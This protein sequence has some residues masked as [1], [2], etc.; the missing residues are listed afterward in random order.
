LWNT[1]QDKF[2]SGLVGALEPMGESL[3]VQLVP[4]AE[5]LGKLVG[6]L[7]PPLSRIGTALA[8]GLVALMPLLQ[9]V[10][11]GLAVGV[12]AIMGALGPAMPQLG[13]AFAE[14]GKALGEF[15]VALAPVA[16]DLVHLFASLVG[17]LPAFIRI[18]EAF[19]PL[20]DPMAKLLAIIV[21]FG[22]TQGILAGLLGVMLGYRALHG[23]A[24]GIHA[25]RL[26]LVA[27]RDAKGVSGVVQALATGGKPMAGMAGGVAGQAAGGAGAA[28]AGAM[29]S[30]FLPGAAVV[31]GSLTALSGIREKE[32]ASSAL[33]TIGGMGATGAGIGA[34]IGTPFFGVGA[35]PAAAIGGALGLGVGGAMAGVRALMGDS[36]DS[37]RGARHGAAGIAEGSTPGS[38]RV[39]SH[40]RTWGLASDSSGH[41][42]SRGNAVDVVGPFLASYRQAV[43]DAGGYAEFHGEGPSR[44]VHAVGDSPM[45][46][47]NATMAS[48]RGGGGAL[49][50][51]SMTVQTGPIS[52]EV[53]L[54]RAIAAGARRAVMELDRDE[55]ERG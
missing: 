28:G 43:R 53:D 31:G 51:L 52:A 7:A 19:L 18:L 27:L 6:A 40:V 39:T 29:A 38:R 5:N 8:V 14:L 9:P 54:E 3:K 2:Q 16:P 30:K 41:H 22:P 12:E 44:H 55:R 23:A 17:I 46:L 33:K 37:W 34:L 49:R 1:F 21:G 25:F 47:A 4:L 13:P 15:G 10:F 48:R 35:V 42:P 26:A 50:P 24:A 32:G 11:E 36:D 20:I 45:D